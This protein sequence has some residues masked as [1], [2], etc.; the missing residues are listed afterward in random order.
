MDDA[1]DVM[2]TWV[3]RKSGLFYRPNRSG[4][5]SNIDDAGRYTQEEA[6]AEASV[7][8]WHMSAHPADEF[9]KEATAAEKAY[10]LL[11]R[12]SSSDPRVNEARQILL[13]GMNKD[14]Q[15]RG[16]AYAVE[17]YGAMTDHEALHTLP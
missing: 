6:E 4:Y 16:I 14:G 10:G 9:V 15:R 1:Q 13:A 8:P 5:T 2:A 12:T 11:W 3:I 7:E 17:K